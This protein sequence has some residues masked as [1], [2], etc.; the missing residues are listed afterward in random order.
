MSQQPAN[1]GSDSSQRHGGEGFM[2]FFEGWIFRLQRER[3]GGESFLQWILG[4]INRYGI[5]AFVSL[6]VAWGGLWAVIGIAAVGAFAGAMASAFGVGA[7]FGFVGDPGVLGPTL[8]IFSLLGGAV[9]GAST[10]PIIVYSGRAGAGGAGEVMSGILG[11]LIAGIILA[12]VILVAKIAVE[13]SLLRARGGRR[14][15][16][17]ESERVWPLFLEVAQS[18]SLGEKNLPALMVLDTHDYGAYAS[19]RHI[20]MGWAFLNQLDDDELA[21]VLAHEL[22]HWRSYDSVGATFVWAC[23]LPVILVYNAA[24]F[25]ASLHPVT[26]VIAWLFLWPFWVCVRLVIVPVFGYFSRKH[27]YE[28]DASAKKAGYGEGLYRALDQMHD[29][30]PGRSG[31]E[32]TVASTHPPTELRLE[33]LEEGQ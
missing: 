22:N 16:R 8:G 14:M 15:S 21:G 26:A 1:Q 31:W 24:W 19:T 10:A 12:A 2:D 11:W 29:I 7:L 20:A 13:K 17:R 33:V 4:G 18:M 23:S 9:A 27:E 28:A 25:I 6:L 32:R 5:S 30:E 3:P